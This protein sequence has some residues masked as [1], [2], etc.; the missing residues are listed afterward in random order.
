MSEFKFA[1]PI[2]GQHITADAKDTGSKISCPTCFRKIVVPQ[3]PTSGDA[4]FV[5]SASEAN[6]PRPPQSTVPETEAFEKR[7]QKTAIPLALIALLVLACGA[8]ATVYALRG[9]IFPSKP[10]QGPAAENS[11]TG[12]SGTQ[13]QPLTQYT[14]TNLWSL[15]LAGAPIPA[16]T[17]A[18]SLHHLAFTLERAT[19]T[20][21]NLTFRIGR[22]G[23][24]ELGLNIYFFNRQAE[25]LSG[26]IAE[27]KPGDPTAPRVVLHWKDTERH[28]ETFHHGYA[29]KIE[30]GQISDNAVPGKIFICLPDDSQS[31]IAGTFMA[32]IHKPGSSKSKVSKPPAQLQTQ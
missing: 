21:S 15:D 11:E 16:T 26:R 3:A 6:K 5:I 8:G 1:C 27:V 12:S 25:E 28:S 22:S 29:M 31:W 19:L 32:E 7:S 17:L 24:V 10:G 4:K 20:G 13:T 14:G 18:G 23:Q 9:K 30:F 2:C